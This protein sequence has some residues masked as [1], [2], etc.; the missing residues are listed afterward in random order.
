[1]S[2][3]PY[4]SASPITARSAQ[5]TV[6]ICNEFYDSLHEYR[7]WSDYCSAYTRAYRLIAHTKDF[8]QAA[9]TIV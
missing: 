5:G 1:M 2:A 4:G 7:A 3:T 9:V 8:V 6:I